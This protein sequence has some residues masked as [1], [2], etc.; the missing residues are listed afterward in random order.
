MTNYEIIR[1]RVPAT[2]QEVEQFEKNLEQTSTN[3][4]ELVAVMPMPSPQFTFLIF[5]VAAK[6]KGLAPDW[7]A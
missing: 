3:G 1:A 6:G 4:G 7:S 2:P 5:R